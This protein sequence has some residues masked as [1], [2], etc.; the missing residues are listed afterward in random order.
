MANPGGDTA[1]IIPFR[2]PAALEALRRR[3]SPDAMAGLPAHATL[4][5]PFAKPEALDDAV[6]TRIENI[7]SAHAEFSCRLTG[8]GQWPGV[9]FASV[10]PEEPFRSLYADLL[11]VFPEFPSH[12][13]KLE[14]V[15]HVTIAEEPAA[16]VPETASD[17]AWQSLPAI[18]HVS[19][20]DLI[21]RG[22]TGWDVKWS[23]AMM[24]EPA[25][26]LRSVS[27]ADLPFLA[28]MA[29]SVSF[30]PGSPPAGASQMPRVVRWTQDWG[31]P[32]DAGI[33]A[34]QNG[35]RIGAAWCRIQDEAL[36]RSETGDALCEV[37]IAV[38]PDHRSH[39]IGAMLLA[40][41]ESEAAKWDQAALSLTVNA[42]NPARR[43]YERA[44]FVLV[45]REGDRL[46]MVKRR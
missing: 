41:L 35:E 21:V 19:R 39:R 22:P 1:L 20:A 11:S 9:L 3:C 43:L 46:T 33:V 10:E 6:R 14:F 34:W 27:I 29:L 12:R 26:E 8:L 32:G 18:H 4:L 36:V 38:S 7:V 40:A 2:L 23:F 5:Y 25:L 28:E 15:A 42:L 30:P 24:G 16:S 44:G 45:R 17:P 31:R 13:G 37:A